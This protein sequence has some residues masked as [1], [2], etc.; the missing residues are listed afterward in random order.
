MPVRE[1]LVEQV[2]EDLELLGLLERIDDDFVVWGEFFMMIEAGLP[3][4]VGYMLGVNPEGALREFRRA[5]E[6]PE[7]LDSML[8]SAASSII[9]AALSAWKVERGLEPV[10][11]RDYVEALLFVTSFILRTAPRENRDILARE[12]KDLMERAVRPPRT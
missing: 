3:R 2:L 5:L 4:L 12:L 9:L 6:D 8:V 11:N 7:K 1:E 10:F